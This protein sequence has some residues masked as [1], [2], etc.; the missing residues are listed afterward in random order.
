[1]ILKAIYTSIWDNAIR[2]ESCCTINTMSGI[3]INVEVSHSGCDKLQKLTDQYVTIDDKK[4]IA[5]DEN[6]ADYEHGK[7]Y[8]PLCNHRKK[9]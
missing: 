8:M 1:M 3:V 9:T 6:E 7:L 2:L 4:Y 5:V